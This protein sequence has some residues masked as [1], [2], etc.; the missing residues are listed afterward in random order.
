MAVLENWEFVPLMIPLPPQRSQRKSMPE[1]SVIIVNWNGKQFLD[2]CLS[3]LRRQT[4][5]DFE[6]IFVDNGSQDGSADYVRWNFPEVKVLALDKNLGFSGGNI[7]GYEIASGTLIALLNNDTEAHPA[8]LAHVQHA[9]RMYPDAGSFASRMMYFDDR[10]RI[11]NC[12]FRVDRSATTVELGRNE[13]YSPKWGCVQKVFGACGGAAVYRRHMLEHIGFL[14]PD[15]FMIY[16]DVD[17][18][19]RAQLAGYDCVYLP[20]AVVYHR[21]R[22]T[23]KR[24]QD[25]QVFYAQRN[26]EFLFLKNLP[27]SF[28]VRS[29]PQRLLYELGATM[30]FLKLGAGSAFV[31][32]KLHA[33]KSL[34]AVLKKRRA[35]QRL[36]IRSAK[37][38]RARMD[39]SA[40]AS[41]WRKLV[42]TKRGRK[43]FSSTPDSIFKGAA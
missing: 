2:D 32:A 40:F 41:K 27:L 7:A 31:R 1:I 9:S 39:G 24:R 28:I 8:W 23:L 33:I 26:I 42:S 15:F 11:E 4:F 37:E 5:R 13:L 10:E 30:Y 22:S 3:A 43:Q 20:Q 18:S 36:R 34:A 29:A 16:E 38:L 17:L 35:V 21:Y 25:L 19:F 6:A 14:D 12:G